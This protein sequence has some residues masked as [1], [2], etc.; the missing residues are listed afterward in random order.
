LSP[1]KHVRVTYIVPLPDGE[2]LNL[3]KLGLSEGKAP[4]KRRSGQSYLPDTVDPQNVGSPSGR[5]LGTSIEQALGLERHVAAAD[6]QYRTPARRTK[7]HPDSESGAQDNWEHSH[8]EAEW[9]GFGRLGGSSTPTNF[10]LIHTEIPAEADVERFLVSNRFGDARLLNQVFAR[11][12]I[13][14]IVYGDGALGGRESN[15]PSDSFSLRFPIMTVTWAIPADSFEPPNPRLLRDHQQWSPREKWAFL[16]ATHQ[17]YHRRIPADTKERA[18]RGILRRMAAWD[19]RVEPFGI[20]I[21]SNALP[22]DI[23]WDQL[24]YLKAEINPFTELAL[25][26]YAQHVNLE[27][28]SHELARESYV[29]G[30]AN[31]DLDAQLNSLN[32]FGL[33]FHR[34]RNSLW[35]DSVPNQGFWTAYLQLIQ[36]RLGTAARLAHVG[37]DYEDWANY[38]R[39]RVA[40]KNEIRSQEARHKS[41]EA[42]GKKEKNEGLIKKYSAV[43]AVAGLAFAL[44]TLLVQAGESDAILWGWICAVLSLAG[45][46]AVY[47]SDRFGVKVQTLTRVPVD[48]QVSAQSPCNQG[49]GECHRSTHRS[50]YNLR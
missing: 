26:A 32:E 47:A 2:V 48:R 12:D 22:K 30:E 33:N 44:L 42:A 14:R 39:N 18:E 16:F 19:V 8:W 20:S 24:Y 37:D 23:G 25:L 45:F 43:A 7:F 6:R 29:Q 1:W 28:F 38:L 13:D 17:P 34:F 50:P 36:E 21:L 41:E 11:L 5:V 3:K 15:A 31:E 46:V 27:S 10:L 49:V 9:V 35:F 4:S 40:E